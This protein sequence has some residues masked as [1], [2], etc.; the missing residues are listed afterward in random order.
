MKTIRCV[1]EKYNGDVISV[2]DDESECGNLVKP[3]TTEACNT[4]ECPKWIVGNWSDV[5]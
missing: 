5:S 4:F 2:S 3:E 1:E